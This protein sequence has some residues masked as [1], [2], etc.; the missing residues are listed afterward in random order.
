MNYKEFFK[1]NKKLDVNTSTE[2]LYKA[3]KSR[4]VEETNVVECN[5]ADEELNAKRPGGWVCPVHG[6][7][8]VF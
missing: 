6:T 1:K 3:F 2:T 5:C 7:R 4:L 8:T